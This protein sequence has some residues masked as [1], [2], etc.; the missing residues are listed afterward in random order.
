MWLMKMTSTILSS[1][2]SGAFALY[3]TLFFLNLKTE[4]HLENWQII[5]LWSCGFRIKYPGF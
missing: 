2:F 1:Y 4:K 3:S 5:K